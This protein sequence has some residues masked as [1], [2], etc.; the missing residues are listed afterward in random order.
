MKK[1]FCFLGFGQVAK[2]FLKK[3][4]KENIDFKFITTSRDPEETKIFNG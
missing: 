2:F 1:K 4:I 3:I